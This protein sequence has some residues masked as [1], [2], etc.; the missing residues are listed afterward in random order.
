MRDQFKVYLYV[1]PTRHLADGFIVEK[2]VSTIVP[3]IMHHSQIL[4]MLWMPYKYPFA[5]ITMGG[6][7]VHRHFSTVNPLFKC[8]VGLT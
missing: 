2:W 3:P 8:R 7:M 6:I 5:H 1:S 4:F